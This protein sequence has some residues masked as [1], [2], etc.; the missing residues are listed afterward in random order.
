M[1]ARAVSQRLFAVSLASRVFP[2]TVSFT[3]T[4]WWPWH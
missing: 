1:A 3:W 4:S 2:D